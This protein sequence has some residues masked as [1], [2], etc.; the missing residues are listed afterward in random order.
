MAA[1][2]PSELEGHVL[3]SPPGE[4]LLEPA[5]KLIVLADDSEASEPSARATTPLG[6]SHIDRAA[7]TRMVPGDSAPQNLVIL[8]WNPKMRG[9]ISQIDEVAAPGSVVTV[10]SRHRPAELEEMEVRELRSYAAPA[11]T[12]LKVTHVAGDASSLTDLAKLE[13]LA[14]ADSVLVLQRGEG[15]EAD[16]AHS[17]LCIHAVQQALA[18]A[19]TSLLDASAPRLIG[20]LSSPEMEQLICE[21]WPGAAEDFVLPRELAS[22]T[23]VQFALQPELAAV[24]LE[25][26]SAEGKEICFMPAEVYVDAGET[27]SFL[28]LNQ[29]ARARGE[30]AVG[31]LRSGESMPELNP[32]QVDK[33]TLNAGDQLVVLGELF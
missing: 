23:L 4:R 12:N 26:L 22:G 25:L 10:L 15:G 28:E 6:R 7:A 33:L 3:L 9:I 18:D 1:A 27:L 31:L 5:D 16:D 19:G 29:R 21:Q 14:R 17:L 8:N 24:F 30:V 11:L 20:E 2:S 32:N 13:C